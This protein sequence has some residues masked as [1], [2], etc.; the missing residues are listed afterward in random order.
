V[1]T[2]GSSDRSWPGELTEIGFPFPAGLSFSCG[3]R[4]FHRRIDLECDLAASE[5]LNSNTDTPPAPRFITGSIPAHVLRMTGAAAFGLMAIFV[6]ELANVL[7]LS[8]LGDVEIIAAVGYASTL[9]FLLLSVGI[10]TAIAASSLIAPAIGAG[11]TARAKALSASI[12]VYAVLFA[13][14]AGVSVWIYVPELVRLIGADGRTHALATGYLRILIP[15]M[16][17][18]SLGMCASAVLRSHGDARRSMNVT[19]IGAFVNVALDPLFIF[20]FGL[21]IQGAA[22]ATNIS[23]IAVAGFGIFWLIR[24]HDLLEWPRL[25]NLVADARTILRFAVPATLTNL[26]TPIANTYVTYTIARHGTAAVAAWALIGRISPVVFGSIFALSG[27]VGPVLGQNLGARQWDRVRTAFDVSVLTAIGF[28]AV[29]WLVLLVAVEP[30]IGLFRVTGETAALV[31]TYCIYLSPMFAFLGIL[32]VCNAALNALG[33]PH[34]PTVLNWARATFGTVPIVTIAG[35]YWG[36][37]GVI[38]GSLAG[39]SVFA[40]FGAWLCRKLI[41]GKVDKAAG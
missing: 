40:L 23:R 3:P 41:A 25:A 31:R 4:Q 20:T 32:F 24:V 17:L 2:R 11:D 28:T 34:W 14:V 21:G 39:A 22:W 16:T 26:A 30:L 35:M 6:G 19:L 9:L 5:P 15:F 10:G 8:M 36:P 7:F 27:A 37:A 38:G 33:H 1:E 13:A 18:M 29:A 12:H